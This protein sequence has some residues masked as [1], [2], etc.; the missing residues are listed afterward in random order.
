MPDAVVE[1]AIAASIVWVAVEN[2]WF[3]RGLTR[4]WLVSLAFGLVHGFGFASA[5]TPL[6]LPPWNLA[7]ALVGFNLGV[8]AG[9]AAVI[10]ATLPLGL[11]LRRRAWAPRVSRA[12]SPAVALVGL[13]WFVQ[14]VFLA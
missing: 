1:P 10:A 5:L 2:L 13:V 9:Q 12:L 11:G 3:A 14:R 8:E 7:L 6:A 4:R